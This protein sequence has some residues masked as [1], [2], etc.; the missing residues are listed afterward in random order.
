MK[1]FLALAG[2]VTVM[3]AGC[4][5][6]AACNEKELIGFDIDLAREVA[7]E[8]DLKVEFKEIDWDVKETELSAKSIDVVWN[9]FTYTQ[10]RDNGYFDEERNAQ[11]GGLDFSKFY[12]KNKQ[13]AVVQ[14]GKEGNFG[15]NAAFK[16]M[17]GC[18]E[19]TSAGETVIRETL[20]CSTMAQIGKQLDVFIAVKAGTFDFG[21]VDLTMASEY[22]LT[23]SG[24]YSDSLAVIELEEV[25]DEFYAIAFREGSDLASVFDYTLAKLFKSGKAQEIAEKYSLGSALYNGFENVDTEG[26]QF[27]DGKDSDYAYVKK[28]G[29]LIIGY[30]V[31]AP[32][33]YFA[34]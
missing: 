14:K 1:K 22:I 29:K 19:A 21:V 23:Q 13:V 11:I 6:L 5:N 2:A 15:N 20:G 9:G 30:T 34:Q 24:A 25:E 26:F 33:A 28:N 10:D 17:Q 31:F 4:L 16:N 8:L 7:A 18:A 32:M 3:A 27:P 12:M